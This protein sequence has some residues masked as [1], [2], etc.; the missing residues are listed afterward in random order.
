VTVA[1]HEIAIGRT[2]V[3][4]RVKRSKARKQ[5]SLV[6]EAGRAGVLVLAPMKTPRSQLEAILRSR[7]PW[8]LAKL[9][10]VARAAEV[11]PEREFVSGESFTYLG[12]SFRLAV[13][14]GDEPGARLHG[15][16]LEVRVR[17]G[18]RPAERR[19]S[20][21]AAVTGWFRTRAAARLASRLERFTE[22][23]GMDAPPV[24]LREQARRWG[25]CAPTG[26]VRLNWRI[27]Q[28]PMALVD[29]VVAHEAVHLKHRNHTPAFWAELA[30]LLPDADIRRAELARRG[31]AWVW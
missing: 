7:A 30:R 29:Y 22:K 26:E 28:A 11:R 17:R 19:R 20:V 3:P 6:V 8:I 16:W 15:G 4:F 31:A 14:R 12:R 2:V 23:L 24:L 27:V 1:R 10:E 21:R 9:R 18:L 13:R 25:S 5:V